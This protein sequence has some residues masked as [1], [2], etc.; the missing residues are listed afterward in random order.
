[1]TI[2]T[3]EEL[4]R[5]PNGTVF[6]SYKPEYLFDEIRIL[7]GRYEDRDGWCGELRLSPIFDF[8]SNEKE[9]YTQWCTIDSSDIDYSD[10]E[11]FVVFSIKEIKQIINCLNWAVKELKGKNPNFINQD[12]WFLGDKTITDA[13]FDKMRNERDK[14]DE[15]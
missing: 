5:L 12:I 9:R 3:K 6:M 7:T 4:K 2:V 13:E 10:Y 1:M 8:D 15:N 11:L 14:N